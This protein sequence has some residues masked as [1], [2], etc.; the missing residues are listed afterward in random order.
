MCNQKYTD[1]EIQKK[2]E[3][4]L[5]MAE[6]AFDNGTSFTTEVDET[7]ETG[8]IAVAILAVKIFDNLEK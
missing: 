2:M 3:R 5:R 6:S 7:D 1:D 8:K 4:A